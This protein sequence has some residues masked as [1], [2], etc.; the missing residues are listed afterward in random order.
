[1]S[2]KTRTIALL[3]VLALS[4]P[5]VAAACPDETVTAAPEGAVSAE[6]APA[7]YT[8][9]ATAAPVKAGTEG[10]AIVTIKIRGGY[11]WNK[12]YPAKAT[13]ATSGDAIGVSKTEFKQTSGDFESEETVAT[14]KIPVNG[15]TAG[16]G[17]LT[18]DT[19]FGVCSD[20]VCLIKKASANVTVVVAD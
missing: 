6:D 3:S 1:M 15:K 12:E 20:K 5:A 14:L 4:V 19:R 18:V 9:E 17:T 11:H 2:L 13:V 8:I 10:F 16:E 7:D